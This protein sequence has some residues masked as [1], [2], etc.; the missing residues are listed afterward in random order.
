M[1]WLY[2]DASA[3]GF[4]Q[5]RFWKLEHHTRAKMET[6]IAIYPASPQQL[7]QIRRQII[8]MILILDSRLPICLPRTDEDL[9]SKR[10]HRAVE[11]LLV[12]DFETFRHGRRICACT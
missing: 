4:Q 12:I 10:R 1:E 3:F 9:L 8:P 5:R 11:R 7:F 6:N 2:Q